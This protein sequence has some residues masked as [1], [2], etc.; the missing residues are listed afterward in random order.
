MKKVLYLF[1][2]LLFIGMSVTAQTKTYRYTYDDAGNRTTRN[3]AYLR[4]ANPNGGNG[5]TAAMENAEYNSAENPD[6]VIAETEAAQIS[7]FPNPTT[8]TVNVAFGKSETQT[9]EMRILDG[10]GKI[11][12][13]KENL[14][15]NFTL[16]FEGLAAGKYYIW[17]RLNGRIERF[18][19]IKQ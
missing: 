7:L 9:D 5:A 8:R 4:V 18:P 14:S 11:V 10:H 1:A 16:P 17:L 19:V 12:L 2:A 13:Q 15:G 3:V 6:A